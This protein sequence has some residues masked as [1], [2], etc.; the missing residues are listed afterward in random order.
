MQVESLATVVGGKK[1]RKQDKIRVEKRVEK[2]QLMSN[3]EINMADAINITD[4]FCTAVV[5]K[6][7]RTEN[8]HF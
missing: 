7:C 1:V 2:C 5:N 6:F 3:F 8:L 4:I